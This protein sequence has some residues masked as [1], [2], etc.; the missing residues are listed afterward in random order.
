MKKK[1]LIPI[2]IISFILIADQW[3]KIWVK[4]SMFIGEELNIFGTW[5]KLHFIEN[6][7]MA[8]GMVFFGGYWG[9][10]ILVVFRMIAVGFIIWIIHKMIKL[11]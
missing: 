9:K 1:S 11:N 3:L 8:F 2:I 7:G 4:T 5:F 10:L 6:E